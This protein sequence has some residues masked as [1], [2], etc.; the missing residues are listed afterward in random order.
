MWV[1]FGAAMVMESQSAR[2]AEE[3][4]PPLYADG[5]YAVLL[6]RYFKSDVGPLDNGFGVTI[7]GGE[8]RGLVALEV[9]ASYTSAHS[10][11]LIGGSLNGLL[12]PFERL[13]GLFGLVGAGMTNVRGYPDLGDTTFNVTTVDGGL[14]Y[15][16]PLHYHNYQFGLRAQVLYEIGKREERSQD[17]NPPQDDLPVHTTLHDVV[18]NIGLQ[19]PFGSMPPPVAAPEPPVAVV[20]L[21]ESPAPP[22]P[23]PPP[24]PACRSPAPGE[25]VNLQG[26]RT[27]DV[28]ILKGV[29]FEFNSANLT[30]NAKA[31][32]DQ[33]AG[34]LAS[35][36]DIKVELAGH[37]DGKGGAL[38][39]QK[40]S[41][42]RAESVRS[43]F[44]AYGVNGERLTAVGFGKTRP[45][46]SNDTDEGRALNRRTELRITAGGAEAQAEPASTAAQEAA[47]SN[48]ADAAPAVVR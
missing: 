5:P 24:Q 32:L 27:G 16:F 45:I 10:S 35:H 12:F 38:Y 31:I 3:V 33:V 46:A 22:P 41:E 47:P 15:I 7:A 34:E 25:Q 43:Y 21:T 28:I 23:P 48:G 37:T 8:R 42:K 14:G 44:I 2:A 30:V 26:C 13:P 19:F 40:L 11:N 1:F 29:N 36:P 6:G 9:S 18:A 20:P 4:A 39:N 17:Q